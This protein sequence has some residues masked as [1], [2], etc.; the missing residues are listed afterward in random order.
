MYNSTNNCR[1]FTNVDSSEYIE[2]YTIDE[3]WRSVENKIGLNSGSILIMSFNWENWYFTTSIFSSEFNDASVFN[4]LVSNMGNI[5]SFSAE[6]CKGISGNTCETN[7]LGHQG[8]N[9]ISSNSGSRYMLTLG[10]DVDNDGYSFL[11]DDLPTEPSQHSDIDQDGF[12]DNFFGLN[13]DDCGSLP[14]NSTIDLKG[15]PDLDGDGYSNSGDLFPIDPFQWNDSDGDGYGDNKPLDGIFGSNN[16]DDCVEIYGTSWRDLYGCV[17]AD[18]DG[19][20]NYSDEFLEDGTQ[21][22]DQDGDGFGDNQQGNN[23]DKF[24]NDAT[25]WFDTD[26]DGYGDNQQGNNPDKFVNDPTQWFD[27]DSDG[28]G[29]EIF[30]NKPDSCVNEFGNSTQDRFGCPDSDGDG[31]SDLNDRFVDDPTRWLDTDSDGFSDEE[32][33]FPFDPS[34]WIDEDGDGM[35]D[36]PMGIGADKFP[37]DNTQWGDIDGDGYGDNPSGNNPDAFITD[38]T[39]WSDTDG[40]GY[41]DNPSGRLADAFPNN[42]TQWID[43]DGDGLGDN[44]S[45]TNGDPYLNDFDNDGYNDSIDLLPKL[46]SPEDLDADG[47]PDE[48]DVFPDN[49]RECSDADNDGIGD[50]ED[51]DD[52][53]DGWTD[54]E[55]IR[56]G[57]NSL[58]STEK[59]V[60]SFEIVLPGTAIGLGAWDLI[61][62]FGGVP[63]FSWLLFGFALVMVAQLELKSEC[64]KHVAVKN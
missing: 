30:G 36:N 18:G 24:V 1:F 9:D 26:N 34:Q 27:T 56:L 42:P 53:N 51:A 32:D 17:D 46:A 58:S 57:T 62:I 39:Q 60:D 55:E 8:I 37:D 59:P 43:E 20:S 35:G 13:F 49:P 38:A 10:E 23:P 45:G 28:Y 44:Q 48:E 2:S 4:V 3:D 63:I 14:G 7:F 61:G 41:G 25:Q 50:N 5:I 40:D 52:D 22:S 31:I 16:W 15:C 54:T 12:G 6:F 47:C 64:V 29:D 19:W 11:L 21:W 33:Q